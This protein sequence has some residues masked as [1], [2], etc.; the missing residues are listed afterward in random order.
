[1][2]HKVAISMPDAVF[3]RLERARRVRKL[4]RSAAVQSALDRW[5]AD[6]RRAREAAEYVEGYRRMPEDATEVGAWLHASA[7]GRYQER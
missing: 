4:S 5:L 1:M 2:T 6:H 7:W 3:K